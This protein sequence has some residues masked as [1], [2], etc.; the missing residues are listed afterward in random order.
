[1]LSRPATTSGEKLVPRE[2]TCRIS[3]FAVDFSNS[4]ARCSVVPVP[5]DPYVST[6]GCERASATSLHI[7]HRQVVVH[8]K[9]VGVGAHLRDRH[10]VPDRVIR[11]PVE[12]GVDGDAG[13]DRELQC[14]AVR[15]CSYDAFPGNVSGGAGYVL[16]HNRFA[17]GVEKLVADDACNDVR[18]MC[19][20]RSPRS[21]EPCA[22]GSR[23][24]PLLRPPP[25][26]LT[27]PPARPFSNSASWHASTGCR[28]PRLVAYR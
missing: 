8:D 7:G 23:F 9:D 25:A 15:L 18:R 17:P 27:A 5:A 28:D 22:S 6:P 1:M 16:D 19:P 14:I 11:H 20:A 24:A 21:A 2:G 4:L 12:I 10:Q 26:A 13:F 3:M